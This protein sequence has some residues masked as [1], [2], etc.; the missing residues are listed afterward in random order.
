MIQTTVIERFMTVVCFTYSIFAGH[1]LF[2]FYLSIF[3]DMRLTTAMASTALGVPIK[4]LDNILTRE[5]ASLLPLGK[6]GKSRQ[7]PV[8]VI[9]QLCVALLLQRELGTPIAKSL[10]I[11]QQLVEG[12][13]QAAIGKLGA[14]TFDIARVRRSLHQAIAQTLEEGSNPTRGRPRQHQKTKRGASF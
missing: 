2:Y 3:I 6:Q 4:F 10:Q 12:A 14:I 5:A 1:Y 7:I 8:A 9:E 13:G 11:A